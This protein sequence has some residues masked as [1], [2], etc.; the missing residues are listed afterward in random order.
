MVF[1]WWQRDGHMPV[2]LTSTFSIKL[3]LVDKY[4][5]PCFHY[6]DKGSSCAGSGKMPSPCS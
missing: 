3:S 5:V 6:R 1:A 2:T 4:D